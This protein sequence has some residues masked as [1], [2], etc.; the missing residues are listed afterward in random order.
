MGTCCPQKKIVSFAS[1]SLL[2]ENVP[3]TVGNKMEW[4]GKCNTIWNER[5]SVYSK[6]GM[7][8]MRSVYT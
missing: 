5:M 7:E 6:E 2:R 3:F 1:L 8:W 4:N